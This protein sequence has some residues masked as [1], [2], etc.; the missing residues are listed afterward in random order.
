MAACTYLTLGLEFDYTQ[1][2]I[3]SIRYFICNTILNH[4]IYDGKNILFFL[5]YLQ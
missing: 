5:I 4:L 2:D 3:N 1:E